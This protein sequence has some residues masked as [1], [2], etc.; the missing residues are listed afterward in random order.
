[1]VLL[2][3]NKISLT[4]LS[5]VGVFS[6]IHLIHPKPVHH[7]HQ[8]DCFESCGHKLFEISEKVYD[9][10]NISMKCSP[11][12]TFGECVEKCYNH[13]DTTISLQFLKKC[14]KAVHQAYS[15]V[16][17][18]KKCLQQN[19]GKA[20]EHC[21]LK[22]AKKALEE[23]IDEEDTVN[24]NTSSDEW[25]QSSGS[26][27]LN[28][29]CRL[30]CLY[31]LLIEKCPGASEGVMNAL[32]APFDVFGKMMKKF[33]GHHSFERSVNS[34]SCKDLFGGNVIENKMNN[35]L[36]TTDKIDAL[37]DTMSN[38]VPSFKP[39][40]P[41]PLEI[42]S[43]PHSKLV[44]KQIIDYPTYDMDY[45]DHSKSGSNYE[46]YYN[47]GE[48]FI[49]DYY[50]GG[51][52]QGQ[53]RNDQNI[54]Y[55]VHYN[56]DGPAQTHTLDVKPSNYR[57]TGPASD[58]CG[59][60]MILNDNEQIPFC[61]TP[62]IYF[63]TTSQ[64]TIEAI[65]LNSGVLEKYS[66]KDVLTEEIYAQYKH[67]M[68]RMRAG[69]SQ[70]SSTFESDFGDDLNNMGKRVSGSRNKLN[71]LGD[72]RHFKGVDNAG[73]FHEEFIK[74]IIENDVGSIGGKLEDVD[75]N[76]MPKHRDES[77]EEFV[78]DSD[79]TFENN[80]H[81]H[82]GD[83]EKS[84]TSTQP[85]TKDDFEDDS[86]HHSL[87]RPLVSTSEN[88]IP[89]SLKGSNSHSGAGGVH[90]D[91]KHSVVGSKMVKKGK[92]V[93]TFHGQ[94]NDFNDRFNNVFPDDENISYGVDGLLVPRSPATRNLVL[95]IIS[96]IV[97]RRTDDH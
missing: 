75:D 86:S 24:S 44:K 84:T 9:S 40:P 14:D 35:S 23:T 2:I 95:P 92:K 12:Y 51:E 61:S 71:H 68:D 54:L 7:G 16:S 94:D 73:S 58:E 67:L 15:G 28:Q 97:G 38:F 39:T 79:S 33:S 13:H 3:T 29:V 25:E 10:G 65:L 74:S 1:M 34:S 82:S 4:L 46:D 18:H 83:R 5:V 42:V 47:G 37:N 96:G 52:P 43:K 90:T 64:N 56:F 91:T 69:S 36:T 19:F 11:Y 80:G 62:T 20:R 89:F 88:E 21:S 85:F 31:D 22:C 49:H 72:L 76:M 30:D 77:N 70:D 41:A 53:S 27:C 60:I 8:K 63:I 26:L 81:M 59:D 93:S 57:F 48:K 78:E 6:S 50:D 55:Q 32:L 17:K 66:S 45:S 87:F